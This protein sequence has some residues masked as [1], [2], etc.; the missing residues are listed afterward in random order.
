MAVLDKVHVASWHELLSKC[1]E[2]KLHVSLDL[3]SSLAAIVIVSCDDIS[4]V[5]LSTLNVEDCSLYDF[6]VNTLAIEFGLSHI[7]LN[8]AVGDFVSVEELFL[9]LGF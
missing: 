2:I 1:V 6:V 3:L 8:C 5:V 4:L 7:C 9:E